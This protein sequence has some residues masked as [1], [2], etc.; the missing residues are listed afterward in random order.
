MKAKYVYATVAGAGAGWG[1]GSL[2]GDTFAAV[3]VGVAVAAAFAALDHI[4]QDAAINF[5]TLKHMVD[6]G[7]IGLTTERPEDPGPPEWAPPTPPSRGDMPGEP[8]EPF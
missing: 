8:D 1:V 4:I 5:L 6:E 3:C 2:G 7:H